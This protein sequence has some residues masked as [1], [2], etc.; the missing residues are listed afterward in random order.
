MKTKILALCLALCSL[1]AAALTTQTNVTVKNFGTQGTVAYLALNQALLDTC[2]YNLLY[3]P[4]V[5]TTQGKMIYTA[6]LIAATQGK[7]IGRIDYTKNPSTEVC[8][9]SLVQFS[10]S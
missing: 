7:T 3:T 8:S 5:S 2:K 10:G 1:P 9:I 6:L 4:D